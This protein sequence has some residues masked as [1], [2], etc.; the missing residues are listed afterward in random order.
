[1]FF[2]PGGRVTALAGAY[3]V[4]GPLQGYGN[5]EDQELIDALERTSRASTEQDYMKG[6][7]DIARIVHDKAYG[8]GF[9]SAG[10]VWFVSNKIPDWG[11]E[12]DKGRG[13]VNLSALVTRRP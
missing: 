6:M 11:L 13:P 9:F 7:A 12:K 2:G 8:P 3:S 10:S 5:K 1:M 4:Y